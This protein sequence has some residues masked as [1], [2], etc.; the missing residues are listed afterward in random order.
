MAGAE[1]YQHTHY[2]TYIYIYDAGAVTYLS[3]Q[4]ITFPYDT[5]HVTYIPTRYVTYLA[6]AGYGVYIL[7]H[8]VIFIYDDWDISTHAIRNLSI[9]NCIYDISTYTIHDIVDTHDT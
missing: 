8:Y 4:S 7:T 6:A 9:C 2:V 3:T 1:S 5:E